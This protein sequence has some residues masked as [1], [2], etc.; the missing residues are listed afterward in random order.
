VTFPHADGSGRVLAQRAD[1]SSAP[2]G[3]TE[4]NRKG[5]VALVRDH[6][7]EPGAPPRA[8]VALEGEVVGRLSAKAKAER[9]ALERL[10]PGAEWPSP[11]A[12]ERWESVVPW[13]AAPWTV[14][15]RT[16]RSIDEL[17]TVVRVAFR[18]GGAGAMW[19]EPPS[20]PAAI[21]RKT[22]VVLLDATGRQSRKLVDPFA[23]TPTDPGPIAFGPDGTLFVATRAFRSTGPYRI[24]S[25]AS[26]GVARPARDLVVPGTRQVGE[27]LLMRCGGAAW[28]VGP[29]V[30]AQAPGHLGVYI[31]KLAAE[32]D[33]SPALTPFSAPLSADVQPIFRLAVTGC[34]QGQAAVAFV[35]PNGRGRGRPG[36]ALVE[37]DATKP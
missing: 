29:A 14:A 33:L 9:A 32:G 28:A 19:W 31:T 30:L 5:T 6:A 20:S 37:W 25:L 17:P 16:G 10:S 23:G 15:K 8:L 24:L 35:V 22:G 13:G 4:A 12:L 36:L 34:S 1:G 11:P 3:L 27:P 18:E 26:D 2:V 21:V 7:F